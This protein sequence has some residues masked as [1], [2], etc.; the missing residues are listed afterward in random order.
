MSGLNIQR[1]R[2]IF[3]DVYDSLNG[4][5]KTGGAQTIILGI[6]RATGAGT[7]YSVDDII[8]LRQTPP[9]AAEYFNATTGAVIATP[10][11]ADLGS[12]SSASNV[13]VTSSALPTGASTSALQS[14]IQASAGSDA[15]KA[16]AVQGV[17]NGKAIT[18]SAGPNLNTSALALESGGNLAE[19]ADATGTDG[20]ATPSRVVLVGG[21][22]DSTIQTL[23]V[24]GLGRILLNPTDQQT[25]ADSL[26]V[27]IASDQGNLGSIA[28]LPASLGI[29]TAANSLSIAPASNAIFVQRSTAFR[30]SASL[31]R[32][33]NTT[34]YGVN[35]VIFGAFELANIGNNNGFIAITDIRFLMNINYLPSGIGNL[36]LFLY[37]VTPPSAVA[38]NGAFSVPSGDRASLLT[39]SG[40]SLG[41][42]ALALGGGSLVLS[43]VKINQF[44]RLTGT[45]LFGYLVTEGAWVPTANSE[46]ATLTV[47]A[48]EA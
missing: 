14:A 35:D 42:P 25:K 37:S 1:L 19:I 21:Q 17:T 8:I 28:N 9:D 24:D 29:A 5:L 31:T 7:G 16:I 34:T 41:T 48:V 40:I 23:K 30:S 2:D 45:S 44:F 6:F 10:D 20:G 46:T 22:H 3:D 15:S 39:P 13:A 27:T 38:D 33:A 18:V 43:L 32:A 11:P 12:V 26:S 36:R 47:I 4:T